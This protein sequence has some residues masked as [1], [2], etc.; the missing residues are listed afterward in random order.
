MLYR[1]F[2]VNG[3]VTDLVFSTA[4]PSFSVPIE[5]HVA[6]VAERFDIDPSQVEA[7]E[8]DENPSPL[9]TLTLPPQEQPEPEPNPQ[10]A[11]LETLA[12]E[13]AEAATELRA[14]RNAKAADALERAAETARAA[15]RA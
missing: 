2:R 11:L 9:A 5:S 1:G 7:F 8:T 6:H 4:G 13:W 3:E 12:D 15:A 14:G 10:S